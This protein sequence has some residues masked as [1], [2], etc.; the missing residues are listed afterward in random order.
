[1]I[2]HYAVY[3]RPSTFYVVYYIPNTFYVNI[4]TYL[5]VICCDS[6]HDIM[7]ATSFVELYQQ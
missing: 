6:H 7:V 2:M 5:P 3:Y 1:M 4:A